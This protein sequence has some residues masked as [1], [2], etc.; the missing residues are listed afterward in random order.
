MSTDARI[1]VATD[2]L[3]LVAVTL[4]M[5]QS[6]LEDRHRFATLLGA[7]VPADW[8]P[9]L[10]DEASMRWVIDHFNVHPGNDGWTKW[11]FLLRRPG[12]RPLAIGNGGFA[13]VPTDDGIVEVGYSIVKAHQR[14]GYAPEAVRGLIAWACANANVT[15][16]VAHTLPELK[17]SIRVLEKCGFSFVGEGAEEGTLKFELNLASL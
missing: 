5:Q 15:R 2:R 17:P 4:D 16:V 7:E 6:E 14:N 9:P 10:T 13:G 11:Y 1:E 12:K 8:P 3:I